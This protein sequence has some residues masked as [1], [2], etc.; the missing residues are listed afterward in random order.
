M[1]C[2]ICESVSQPYSALHKV[3]VRNNVA[4]LCESCLPDVFSECS[5]VVMEKSIS[6]AYAADNVLGLQ[7]VIDLMQV[8]EQ[9]ITQ[10]KEKSAKKLSKIK[11]AKKRR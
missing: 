7:K 3:N 8:H 5:K 9:D 4:Y 6:G 1:K 11:K 2:A 10:K